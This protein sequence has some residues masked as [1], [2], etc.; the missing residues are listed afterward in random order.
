DDTNDTCVW[1]NGDN[2]I[3]SVFNAL[4]GASGCV[5]PDPT[6]VFP[7]TTLVPRMGCDEAGRVRAYRDLA[8]TVPAGVS[9]DALIVTVKDSDNN[10]VTGFTDLSPDTSGSIDLG[11]LDPAVT[12]THPSF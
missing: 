6:V 9:R 7:Y 12:G 3:I 10:P 2:G 4:T 1:T 5:Q 8:L 11:A